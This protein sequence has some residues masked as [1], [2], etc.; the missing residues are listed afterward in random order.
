MRSTTKCDQ[1]II[2]VSKLYG[3]SAAVRTADREDFLT[4]SLTR[5]VKESV[6]KARLSL[7]FRGELI[8]LL[9]VLVE[10]L[11]CDRCLSTA[12]NSCADGSI[13][14]I[15]CRRAD[16]GSRTSMP[17]CDLWHASF[18]SRMKQNVGQDLCA[19]SDQRCLARDRSFRFS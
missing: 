16:H 3:S 4:M 1:I 18:A 12:P 8:G 17:L 2:S 19:I 11:A 7:A 13:L 10:A 5:S 14:Q 9:V 6:K 15:P